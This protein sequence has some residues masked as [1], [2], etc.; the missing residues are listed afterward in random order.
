[1]PSAIAF[2]KMFNVSSGRTNIV[3]NDTMCR[4]CMKSVC[5][6]NVGELLGD[7]LFGSE[8]KSLIF[9]INNPL[10]TELAK[11]KLAEAITKYVRNVTVN[12]S[13]ISFSVD[14]TKT[15]ISMTIFYRSKMTGQSDMLEIK[16][17]SDGSVTT[18]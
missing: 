17:L 4:Q 6:S 11:Q 14:S 1:M 10:L 16:V 5:L 18:I 15:K 8:L 12:S 9:E 3:Y 2:P 13:D 7:P